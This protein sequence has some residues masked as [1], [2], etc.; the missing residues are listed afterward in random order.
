M[1]SH[2]GILVGIGS[3]DTGETRL[4]DVEYC[5]HVLSDGVGEGTLLLSLPD[6]PSLAGSGVTLT[7]ANG[8]TVAVFLH[9]P[10]QNKKRIAAT[11]VGQIPG[12]Y[13]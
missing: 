7:L 11:T 2:I 6:F 3:I 12:F 5:I 13:W 1:L 8:E 9:H 10:D 4:V